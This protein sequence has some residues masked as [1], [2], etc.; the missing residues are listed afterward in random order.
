[1]ISK[2]LL[3]IGQYEWETT[4]FLSKR[5]YALDILNYKRKKYTESVVSVPDDGLACCGAMLYEE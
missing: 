5:T 3:F 2:R 4:I 1:M